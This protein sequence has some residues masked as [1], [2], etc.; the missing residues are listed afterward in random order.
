LS[1]GTTEKRICDILTDPLRI[2]SLLP[3]VF[4]ALEEYTEYAIAGTRW[5]RTRLGERKPIPWMQRRLIFERDGKCCRGCGMPLT[6]KTAQIDHI[7]PWS[8]GGPDCSCNL[9]VMCEPCNF[10]RSNYRGGLDLADRRPHVT[11]DCAACAHLVTG[12]PEP[13]GIVPGLIP[14]YCGTCGIVSAACPAEVC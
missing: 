8:A 11:L 6:P 3:A 7:V 5:P 1:T 4:N 13:Y 12:S 9:R 14:A 2:G 10:D